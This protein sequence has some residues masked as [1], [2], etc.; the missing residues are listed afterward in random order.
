MEK[1]RDKKRFARQN[2]R[3]RNLELDDLDHFDDIDIAEDRRA[4]KKLVDKSRR[5]QKSG[6][7]LK[8]GLVLEV[9][10]NHQCLV[11]MEEQDILCIL[12]GRLKQMNYETTVLVTAGDRVRVHE[13]DPPRIEEI[14]PRKTTLTRWSE[15]SFQRPVPVAANADQ[16]VITVSWEEPELKTGLIDRYICAAAIAEIKPLICCNKI[17]LA[18]NPE[19]VLRSLA[20]YNEK[21]YACIL[22]SVENGEG[23]EELKHHLAS[24]ISVFSGPSG[25]GK[26]SIIDH[27]LPHFKLRIGQVSESTGKGQ[28]TTTRA[29]LLDFPGGGFLIDTPGIKTFSL[30]RNDIQHIPR[31]F[32]G[33]GTLARNCQFPDCTHTHETNCAVKDALDHSIP[34]E[35]Y[36]SYQRILESLS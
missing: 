2:V 13:A 11:R 12:G 7:D 3:L 29:R 32:P 22:T 21:G 33:F 18:D 1:K 36:D 5:S 23:L 10:A 34:V 30:S 6:L 8:D 26:S 25:V 17:D 31:V 14:I 9:R 4:E 24:S 27:L 20:Y 19:T 16:V 15:G 28:H 35:R